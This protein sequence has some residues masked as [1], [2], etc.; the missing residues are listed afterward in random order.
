[1]GWP[2]P[3]GTTTLESDGL[4]A[5]VPGLCKFSQEASLGA[6][7]AQGPAV[8]QQGKTHCCSHVCQHSSAPIK[9]QILDPLHA[10]ANSALPHPRPQQTHPYTPN[11]RC[12][13]DGGWLLCSLPVAANLASL[14][15]R[16]FYVAAK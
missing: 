7:P 14:K 2:G 13:C 11:P 3:S 16:S 10:L 5:T 9:P 1:M 8:S 12:H 6:I 4:V 15:Y